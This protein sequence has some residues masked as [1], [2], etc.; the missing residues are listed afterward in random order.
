MALTTAGLLLDGL[1]QPSACLTTRPICER[2]RDADIPRP[3]RLLGRRMSMSPSATG[4]AARPSISPAP[5][6]VLAVTGPCCRGRRRHRLKMMNVN[7]TWVSDTSDPHRGRRRVRSAALRTIAEHP[8]WPSTT[9][10]LSRQADAGRSP[11]AR[12]HLRRQVYLDIAQQASSQSNSASPSSC[13]R[14]M[15]DRHRSRSIGFSRRP[16]SV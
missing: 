5:L 15:S 13:R 2:R 11:S 4:S 6:S 14:G 16:H 9:S 7:L 1:D 10:V 8:A 3:R 12:L